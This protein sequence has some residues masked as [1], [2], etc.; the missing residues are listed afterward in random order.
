[1]D[2]F[3][4]PAF[5]RNLRT[6]TMKPS[7]TGNRRPGRDIRWPAREPIA[8]KRGQALSEHLSL[9]WLARRY[10]K[11]AVWPD[12]AAGCGGAVRSCSSADRNDRE[13]NAWGRTA[14][15]EKI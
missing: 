4:N 12:S 8:V 5:D 6:G 7:S 3:V 15:A 11:L 2:G 9:F 14:G 1:M 10:A 13:G